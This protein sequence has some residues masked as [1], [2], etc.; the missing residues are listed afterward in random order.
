MEFRI[1]LISCRK[2]IS[3]ACNV[4]QKQN[5]NKILSNIE[6]FGGKKTEFFTSFVRRRRKANT[7]RGTRLWGVCYKSSLILARTALWRRHVWKMVKYSWDTKHGCTH[8]PTYIY[9]SIFQVQAMLIFPKSI[10]WMPKIVGKDR[11]TESQFNLEYLPVFWAHSVTISVGHGSHFFEAVD[12]RLLQYRYVDL[13]EVVQKIRDS[14]DFP[15]IWNLKSA[16][17]YLS[18]KSEE[19]FVAVFGFSLNEDSKN[20]PEENWWWSDCRLPFNL[21][22]LILAWPNPMICNIAY[23]EADL[24]FQHVRVKITIRS[25]PCGTVYSSRIWD[26][27]W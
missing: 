10:L 12:I 21:L 7:S 22:T 16:E 23:T 24:M 5:N 11:I 17:E 13:S 14:F 26:E 2:D 9:R 18:G 19:D 25:L 3:H 8:V 1:S 15:V 4:A 6:I 27:R 20:N